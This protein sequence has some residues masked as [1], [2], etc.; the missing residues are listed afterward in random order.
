MLNLGSDAVSI[1]LEWLEPEQC[2][3]VK[4]LAKLHKYECRS[5]PSHRGQPQLNLTVTV[6]LHSWFASSQAMGAFMLRLC[7]LVKLGELHKTSLPEKFWGQ[8]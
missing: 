8:C 2:K 4:D 5:V 6:R 3:L 1:K 7:E